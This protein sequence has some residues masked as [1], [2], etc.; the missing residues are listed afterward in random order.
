MERPA[1]GCDY[2]AQDSNG[3]EC[4]ELQEHEQIRAA[5]SKLGRNR[6]YRSHKDQTR[7]RNAFVDPRACIGSVHSND[8]PNN[9]LPKDDSNDSRA[10]R[11]Q[12]RHRAPCEKKSRPLSKDL[13]EVHLRSTIEGNRTSQLRVTRRTRP[14]QQS[15]NSPDDQSR[16]RRSRITIDRSG[17]RK[18]ARS[19]DQAHDQRQAIHEG[20]ALVLLQA[21]LSC[22]HIRR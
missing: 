5:G 14:R 4:D 13:A 15:S 8:R 22:F 9:V 12:Y 2:D 18:D 6:V 7:H 21:L 16:A 1:G 19:N 10:T 20:Q 17:R 3:Q 11:F